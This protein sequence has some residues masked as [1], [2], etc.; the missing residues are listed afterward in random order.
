MR[1]SYSLRLMLDRLAVNDGVFELLHN[2]LVN[3]VTLIQLVSADEW[4]LEPYKV[5]NCTGR[6]SQDDG[7]RV[8]GHPSLGLGVH[9]AKVELLPHLLQK[10]VDVP[11]VLRTDWAGVRN[12]VDQIELLDRYGINLVQRIDDRDVAPALRF[13]HV[14]QVVDSRVASD[15]NIRVGHAVFAQHGLNLVV[16]NVRQRHG[17]CDVDAT[18]LLLLEHNV[19]RALV[20]AD[21]EAFQFVLDNALVGKGLIDVQDDENQMARLRNSDDLSSAT[22]SVLGTLDNSGKIENLNLGT[23]VHNLAGNSGELHLVRKRTEGRSRR[24]VTVV[25]S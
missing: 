17:R 21:A 18:L 2:R 5:F 24:F 14:N 6:R 9:S 20:D 12:A 15:S 10:L 4:R 23:V 11:A 3:R 1:K 16:V 19:G 25:N 7:L 13:N 22:L 8:I